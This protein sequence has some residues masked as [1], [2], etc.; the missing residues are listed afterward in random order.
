[1]SESWYYSADGR[2]KSGPVS[3]PALR[4][5][6]QSGGLN[7]GTLLW[8]EG[9][10]EW[11]PFASLFPPQPAAPV[12][13]A[14]S[15]ETHP[16]RRYCARQAD[17]LLIGVPA[18]ILALLLPMA[19][20]GAQSPVIKLVENHFVAGVL[21]VLIYPFVE[22]FFLASW[23]FTPCRA[24]MGIYVRNRDG[25]KLSYKR[26]LA[27][28]WQVAVFGLGLGIPLVSL[29][30][31]ISGY[32]RLQEQSVTHWDDDLAI[33]VRHRPWGAVRGLCSVLLCAVTFAT[34]GFINMPKTP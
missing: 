24:V 32:K 27:R 4:E 11:Q 1:M 7:A 29:I 12:T 16:W 31:C 33:D 3:E 8:R 17:S 13:G 18:M 2:E 34:I 14:W 6:A 5:L 23:G 9:M 15:G 30:T 26:A 25:S 28:S 22:A 10:A 19:Y 20:F 21:L